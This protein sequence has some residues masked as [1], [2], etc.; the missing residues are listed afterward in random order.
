ML[1]PHLKVKKLHNVFMLIKKEDESLSFKYSSTYLSS[2][3][4]ERI[5]DALLPLSKY[6]DEKRKKET[7]IIV[8]N[9]S[10]IFFN[11]SFFIFFL[12][13][14]VITFIGGPKEKSILR[15]DII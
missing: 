3:S 4:S 11:K 10:I 6:K 14:L 7:N 5:K 15:Y 12:H 8:K 13:F 2:I 1:F 9:N